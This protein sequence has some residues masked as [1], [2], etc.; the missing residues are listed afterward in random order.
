M[1]LRFDERGAGV[2]RRCRRDPDREAGRLLL[3]KVDGSVEETQKLLE[4]VRLVREIR[5]GVVAERQRREVGESRTEHVE[6]RPE[7]RGE[8]RIV[9][10]DR[11]QIG[12]E[13]ARAAVD[14]RQVEME[15]R[16]GLA[17][18]PRGARHREDVVPAGLGG[19]PRQLEREK[20]G[21][22]ATDRIERALSLRG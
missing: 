15:H 10:R 3:Q 20:R 2:H 9:E 5:V 4:L 16:P 7:P 12:R 22:G 21:A 8:L 14:E 18:Q 13:L 6:Q 17:E 19:R 1:E 11:G